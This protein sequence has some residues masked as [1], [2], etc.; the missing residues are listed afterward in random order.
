[1]RE[2]SY[3]H[4]ELDSGAIVPQAPIETEQKWMLNQVQHDGDGGMAK[5]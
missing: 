1:M 3:R 5:Q 4:P 2:I